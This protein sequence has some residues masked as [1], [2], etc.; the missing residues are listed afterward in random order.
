M[1]DDGYGSELWK[2][3]QSVTANSKDGISAPV[4]ANSRDGINVPA[5][6]GKGSGRKHAA[7]ADQPSRTPLLERLGRAFSLRR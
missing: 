7:A 4:T 6:T 3:V 1:P 2:A 5:I